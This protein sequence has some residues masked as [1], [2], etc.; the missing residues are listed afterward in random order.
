MHTYILD[1]T[2]WKVLLKSSQ[3]QILKDV[4]RFKNE[5]DTIFLKKLMFDA[6]TGPYRGGNRSILPFGP[7]TQT[8]YPI[9]FSWL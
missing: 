1:R 8:I 9:M 4:V 2:K 6:R 7:A 5:C 3:T